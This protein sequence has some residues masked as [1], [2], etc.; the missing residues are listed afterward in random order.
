MYKIKEGTI[1]RI[2]NTE[3][4]DKL[5]VVT[6]IDKWDVLGTEVY[7]YTVVGYKSGSVDYTLQWDGEDIK[8]I[9]YL[10]GQIE[11]Y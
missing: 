7:A 5:A 3:N 1:V 10:D 2:L 11:K 8:S 9:I 6:A 4:Y